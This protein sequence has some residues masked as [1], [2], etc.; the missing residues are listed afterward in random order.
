MLISLLGVTLVIC[1]H[2]G[3]AQLVTCSS[4]CAVG[5]SVALLSSFII[6]WPY[7][8]SEVFDI[9]ALYKSDYY[10]YY[11]TQWTV[12][13]SV[14]GVVSLW[15]FCLCMKYLGNCWTDFRQIHMED[16]FGPL[17][18]RVWRSRS[19]VKVTRDKTGKLLRHPHW[20]CTVRRA[21][22]AANVVQQ[23]TRPFR[24]RRGV[25]WWRECTVVGTFGGLRVVYVW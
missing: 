16:A 18:G 24:G 2:C 4:D 17:L 5:P 15:F 1:R 7:S 21:P 13:G 10:Y 23:Q 14:V 12:K 9:L 19:K 22:Y 3:L 25:T 6:R 11:H 8:A 20:R